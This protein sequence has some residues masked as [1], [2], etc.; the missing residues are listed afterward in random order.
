MSQKAKQ[1][2]DVNVTETFVETF[3][4]QLEESLS[5]LS[6]ENDER[7][8]AYL[9]AIK[10]MNKFNGDYRNTIRGLYEESKSTNEE[11]LKGFSSSISERL[12][13]EPSQNSQEFVQQWRDLASRFEEMALTPVNQTFNMIERIEKRVEQNTEEYI[14]YSRNRRAAWTSVTNEYIKILREQNKAFAGRMEESFRT[15]VQTGTN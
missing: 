3:W 14:K 10:Q 13:K 2:N 9:N 6:K 4:D 7:S 5:R 11:L 12:E 1:K 15:L 8:E